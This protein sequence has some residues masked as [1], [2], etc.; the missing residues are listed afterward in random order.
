MRAWCLNRSYKFYMSRIYY[1]ISYYFFKLGHIAL[2]TAVGIKY[3][4][5]VKI[6]SGFVDQWTADAIKALGIFPLPG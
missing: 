2:K 4:P 1:L 5:L 6:V 3:D